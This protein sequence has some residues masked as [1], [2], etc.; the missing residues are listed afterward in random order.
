MVYSARSS[1][2]SERCARLGPLPVV[3]F[4]RL[5]RFETT[6]TIIS[7]TPLCFAKRGEFAPVC[8]GWTLSLG[9]PPD[10]RA[11]TFLF[12]LMASFSELCALESCG[13][14]TIAL[15]TSSPRDMPPLC[16]L[17]ASSGQYTSC[18]VAFLPFF[19][20]LLVF[21]GRSLPFCLAAHLLQQ[22]AFSAY[23]VF[24]L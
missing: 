15:A 5:G 1:A 22:S 6:T 2:F 19:V 21:C 18:I 11:S 12:F 4:L 24:A 23:L 7:S 8:L 20:G 14:Y 9:G 16:R 17:T 10:S 13:V 3:G